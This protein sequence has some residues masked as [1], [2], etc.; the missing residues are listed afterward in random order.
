MA[1]EEKI[2]QVEELAEKASQS[3]AVVFSDY[4]GLT[5][6]EMFELRKK[7]TELGADLRVVKNTLLRLAMAKAGLK[8]GEI[9]GPTSALFSRGADPIESIKTLAMFLKEKGKGA[10][11]FGFFE[12]ALVKLDRLTELAE[13]LPK[14]ALQARLVSQ[15]K[16]PLFKLAYVLSA[17]QQK[18][19]LVLDRVAKSRG[20]VNQ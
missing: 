15:L 16:S 10:L 13:I 7:L 20:G 8:G 12:K 3:G 5:V 4:S 11:K 17:Q 19:V 9:E 1:S 14:P 18:L 2:K 6:T